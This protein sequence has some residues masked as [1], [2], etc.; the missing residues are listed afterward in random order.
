MKRLTLISIGLVLILNLLTPVETSIAFSVKSVK[1]IQ[2]IAV[3]QEEFIGSISLTEANLYENDYDSKYLFPMQG[4]CMT[5]DGKIAVIDNSYGRVHVLNSLL[6][7]SYTFGSLAQLVYPTDIAYYSNNFY[8]ADALGGGVKVFSKSG[9]FSKTISNGM[10]TP[11]GVTVLKDGIFVSDYFG[12]KIFKLD[13]N[14]NIIKTYPIN[15]PGGL[16]SDGSKT[17]I[18]ISMLEN[19]IFIFDTN[20][21]LLSSFT[22]NELVFPSDSVI[23]SKGNICIV[24]RGLSKGNGANGRVVIYSASGNLVTTIGTAATVYPNQ[25]D[26]SFLTPCGIAVD[27]FGSIYVMDGGYFYWSLDSDAPF[28]SPIGA[29]LSVFTSTGIFLS[30]KDFLHNNQGILTNP[31]GVTLDE[32][33]NMWVINN[34]GFNSSELDEFSLSGKFVKSITKMGADNLSGA[35]SVFSDKKGSIFVGMKNAIAVFANSGAFKSVIRSDSIGFVRK[36]IKGTD[37]NLYATNEDK[38]SVVEFNTQGKIIKSFSVCSSPSGITQSSK[39]NFFISSLSDS[40]IYVYDTNFKFLRTIGQ[41]GGRGSLQFYIPEDVAIDKYGNLVVA[42]TENGRLSF[43]S[44]DGALLFQTERSFYETISIESEGDTFLLA[45][46]FHNI[47]RVVSEEVENELYSFYVSIYPD[48]FV[49]APSDSDTFIITVG[50]S[51]TNSDTY[52][53]SVKNNLPPGWNYQVLESASLTF[54]IDPNGTRAIKV[55][56]SASKTAKDGDKGNLIFSVTSSNSKIIKTVNANI[57]VS[58]NLPLTIYS[59]DIF[60]PNADTF[61][62]PIFVKNANN[63]KGVAF[64]LP[65]N[66]NALSLSG[67]ELPLGATDNLLAYSETSAG[68]TVATYAPNGKAVDGMMQIL[69]IKFKAKNISTNSIDF[70]NVLVQ[71][72]LDESMDYNKKSS[73]ITI[74]PYLWLSFIDGAVSTTQ[75]FSFT[76]KTNAGCTVTVNG[77]PVQIKSDGS[78]SASI[79]LLYNTNQV[80]VTAK[81]LSGEQTATSKTV[82]YSGKKKITIV[83]QVG[84]P[85]MEV[86]GVKKE[87]DP[88][89]GTSPII[90]AG[91]NRTIVPVRAIVE[92]L[93][94]T[95]SWNDREQLV[96]V[97]FINKTIKLWINNP[98]AEVN[99]V[100]LNIDED[101]KDVKPIIIN[102]RT[103]LPIRFVAENLGCTV[104]WDDTTKKI[105]IYYED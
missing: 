73:T 31:T 19:K 52:S 88:G 78:F 71:N 5:D 18:A 21:N 3:P 93:G 76:G 59:Q 34:G 92:T 40:K 16:S 69:N 11:N 89:R 17:V 10:N 86:N 68:L 32:N 60:A 30:K 9:L 87:I 54:T 41:G 103:M 8:I 101:N 48:T 49:L 20:L 4:I 84:N 43:F 45:D 37:G 15:F 58:T 79:S 23:D 64:D 95:I 100:K 44:Q 62:V 65:Y 96:S 105:T 25:K 42:D 2:D 6:Q 57:L 102:S 82:Y 28:G 70:Q 13:L 94:G 46:C 91:W 104:S 27:S 7:N 14:G 38:D 35:F 29:R 56:V 90:L 75:T 33:G 12:G 1:I 36:I 67:I 72:V 53:V 83:M 74:G 77:S 24:D 80:T 85:I 63:I 39:G 22:G 47:I 26:G 99:G 61:S 51:G 81:A 55:N 50:N 66:K 97:L 98:V